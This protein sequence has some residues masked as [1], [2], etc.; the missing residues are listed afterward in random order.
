MAG[1][2]VRVKLVKLD[3]ESDTVFPVGTVKEGWSVGSPE[4]GRAF[5][6][7]QDDGRLFRTGKIREVDQSGFRTANSRY[8]C[9]VVNVDLEDTDDELEGISDSGSKARDVTVRCVDGSTV[10]GKMLNAEVFQGGSEDLVV[11]FGASV[12]GSPKKTVVL[13]RRALVWIALDQQ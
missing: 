4:A 12:D 8:G 10:S 3:S 11:L 5:F 7:I 9:E 13:N 6:I 1:M 2:P